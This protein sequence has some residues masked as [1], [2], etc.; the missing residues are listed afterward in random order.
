MNA[1]SGVGRRRMATTGGLVAVA[2]AV[3]ALA[4]V[5]VVREGRRAPADGN[6]DVASAVQVQP[7]AGA[8]VGDQVP[9][10]TARS[11]DG[12][13][14]VLPADR[15]TAVFFF[16]GWCGTCVP[17]AAALGELHRTHGDKVNIIAVDV[18]PTDAPE[19]ISGFLEAAGDPQ[20]P[21]VHD[22]DGAMRT[23]FGVASLD[24]TVVI[25][26]SGRVVYRDAVP[27]TLEQLREAFS[28]AGASV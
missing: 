24:V 6:S 22:I 27:S 17:E 23:A 19:T 4:G 26:A 21:V 10:V 12:Q 15:S 25:D 11:L 28:Q 9:A 14:V 1:R 18:D 5:A 13:T 2:V 8:D 7:T 20:Y 3:V 16:A